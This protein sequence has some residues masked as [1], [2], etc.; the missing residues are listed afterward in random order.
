[1]TVNIKTLA[2]ILLVAVAMLPRIS[3]G[4]EYVF[5][6]EK[7][8]G[9]SLELIVRSAS[10]SEAQMAESTVL[11][12]IQRLS[13]ILSEWSPDSEV[14]RQLAAGEG[15]REI[16]PDLHAVLALCD[17]W[18]HLSHGAFNPRAKVVARLWS[19]AE[20]RQS[21]PT[22]AELAAAVASCEEGAWQL[23]KNSFQVHFTG[24]AD[25]TLNG[26]SKD[27]IIDQAGQKAFAALP[28]GDE[29]SLLLNIGGD[30]RHWGDQAMTAGITDPKASAENQMPVCVV[31]LQDRALATSGNY[32]RGWD[33]AGKH[34]SHVV[35]PH[36]GQPATAV[37]SVS[38]LAEDAVKANALA[39]S[40]SLMPIERAMALASEQGAHCLIITNDGQVH[41]S[42]Y[43]PEHVDTVVAQAPSNNQVV[44]PAPGDAK[45]E[46]TLTFE[47]PNFGKR[48]FVAAWIADK[49]GFPV[50][51]LVLWIG[52]GGRHLKYLPD[53]RQWYKDDKTRRLVDSTDLIST[54]G[55]ATRRGGI[56][57]AVWDGLDDH[58]TP[59]APGDYFLELEAAREHGSHQ[60][61]KQP[62]TWNG[63]PFEIAI[64]GNPEISSASL[65]CVLPV[66]K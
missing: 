36:S 50:R 60:L 33:I 41:R 11:A 56:Y 2:G 59:L 43:W 49:D 21:L 39:V 58:S 37:A 64:P 46:V 9:T 47:I 17:Q 3:Q 12:E 35:D 14:S 24:K 1:M 25:V 61:I 55:S 13:A 62:F 53:L 4:A 38:V 6:H 54:R 57:N 26:V 22:H 42:R 29:R 23:Q 7:I 5:R 18:Q 34:Y 28:S 19:E 31:D 52:Q 10:E 15:T 48:P 45:P 32:R 16:S 44:Q 8:L 51:T 27:Y 30:L 40:L 66:P 65:K 63:Q 20:K